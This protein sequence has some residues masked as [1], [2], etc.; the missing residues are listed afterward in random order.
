MPTG[1]RP[2]NAEGKSHHVCARVRAADHTVIVTV[3]EDSVPAPLH[4][5]YEGPD[6]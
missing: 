5:A 2:K 3:D 1:G 4:Q 6:T